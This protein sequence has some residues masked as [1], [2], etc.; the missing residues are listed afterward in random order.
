MLLLKRY[1]LC[2][3]CINA[4]AIA[5]IALLLLHPFNLYTE[6]SFVPLHHRHTYRQMCTQIPKPKRKLPE[7][8]TLSLARSLI[9]WLNHT[10][11]RAR[12]HVKSNC[13]LS[14]VLCHRQLTLHSNAISNRRIRFISFFVFSL[15]ESHLTW[16]LILFVSVFSFGFNLSSH[17]NRP[18]CTIAKYNYDNTNSK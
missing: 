9:H 12:T 15:P 4:N 17:L 16:F 14:S 18:L 3:A 11:T 5:A 10:R 2:D 13:C 6:K 7:P 1:T 8:Q